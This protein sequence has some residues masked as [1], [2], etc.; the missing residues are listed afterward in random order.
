MNW[1][2]P[3]FRCFASDLAMARDV[4]DLLAATSSVIMGLALDLRR[5]INRE[6]CPADALLE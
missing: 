5:G 4:I 6:A 1:C 3:V 2:E